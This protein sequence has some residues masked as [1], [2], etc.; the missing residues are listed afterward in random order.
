MHE[1]KKLNLRIYSKY[2]AFVKA[3]PGYRPELYI[4]SKHIF[5]PAP[6]HPFKVK[7]VLV[8]NIL[9]ARTEE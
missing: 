5:E 3:L 9:R 2:V 7:N 1:L 8:A 4:E 6:F